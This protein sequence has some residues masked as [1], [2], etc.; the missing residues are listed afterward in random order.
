MKLHHYLLLILTAG[1]L[2]QSPL[3]AQGQQAFVTFSGIVTDARSDDPLPGAYILIKRAGRGTVTNAIGYFAIPVIPGDTITF[4]YVGYKPQYHIIP[5]RVELS[6]S[7]IIELREDAKVL[8]EV[9]V[10]PY[11]TEEE[12]KQ[13]FLDMTLPDQKEREALAKN[14]DPEQLLRL[15]NAIGMSSMGNYRYF[16]DQQVSSSANRMFNSYNSL[17]NPFAWANFIKSVKRGDLKKKGYADG[18]KFAPPENIK[19]SDF[20]KKNTDN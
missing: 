15:S 19:R 14:T 10:Y 5:K 3:L 13:A 17:L 1:L 9:K 7:A 16:L 4:S 2:G 18:Y 20:I 8:Q 11:R 6:Y 12:F